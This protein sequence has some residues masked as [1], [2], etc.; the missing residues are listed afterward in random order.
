MLEPEVAH[1]PRLE[2]DG[3][4]PRYVE[5]NKIGETDPQ[6][7]EEE[8]DPN[9]GI[10]LSPLAQEVQNALEK[11]LHAML[12]D[13]FEEGTEFYEERRAKRRAQKNKE[14]EEPA[15]M[16]TEILE[17]VKAAMKEREQNEQFVNN[18]MLAYIW[19]QRR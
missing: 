3:R 19:R 10:V 11:F 18:M 15:S 2:T 4:P 7:L 6:P 12:M 9:F 1:Y 14:K 16:I 8:T 5:S 13:Y 17:Q